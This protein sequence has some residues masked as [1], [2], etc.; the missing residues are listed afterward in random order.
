MDR[1]NWFT[2]ETSIQPIKN[3]TSMKKVLIISTSFEQ[4]NQV[5]Q[6]FE[7]AP[8]FPGGISFETTSSFGQ[9]IGWWSIQGPDLLILNLPDDP[10]LQGYFFTKLRRD[11]P[12]TQ[13][14]II[15]CS[16]ITSSMLNLSMEFVKL[17]MLKAP[18]DSFTLYRT[19]VDILTEYKPGQQQIHPRYL[20]NQDIEV[21]SDFKQGRWNATMKNLSLSGVYFEM[22]SV[23]KNIQVGDL[24]KISVIGSQAKN[25][26]FDGKV[27]WAKDK[28]DES[29]GF[30]VAFIDQNE[31][32]N[33]LLKNI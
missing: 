23:E 25:T 4:E 7:K 1:K 16:T 31:V 13:P 5:K 26:I 33:Q 19:I 24:I 28:D 22:P 3:N 2:M 9:D 27:V 6:V 21:Y 17:R 29:T 30:G 8:E 20:T 14:M 12:P 15:T 11:V 10:V 32:Y 18:V